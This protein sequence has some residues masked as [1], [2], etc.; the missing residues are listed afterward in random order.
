MPRVGER[1]PE[2]ELRDQK[3]TAVRLGELLEKGP[4]VIFFYPK[5]DTAGCTKEACRFRDEFERFRQTGAQ[6]VGVSSDSVESHLRF[7][8]KYTLPYTLLSDPGGRV[9]KLYGATSFFGLIPGRA[10]F[11]IDRKGIVRHVFS[12]QSR[13]EEHVDE[14][15]RGL[16]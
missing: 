8:A 2:F 5:D 1:A 14:A 13:F 9:R 4:V 16:A 11:V 12:S 7:A 6:I 10:T 3:G 15:L